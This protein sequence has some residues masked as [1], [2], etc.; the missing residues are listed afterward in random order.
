MEFAFKME[1]LILNNLTTTSL[2]LVTPNINKRTSKYKIQQTVG[3]FICAPVSV[4]PIFANPS[5]Y[6]KEVTYFKNVMFIYDV[7]MDYLC[8]VSVRC[9]TL[10]TAFDLTKTSPGIISPRA[11][12]T[13]PFA[14]SVYTLCAL[15]LPTAGTR[16]AVGPF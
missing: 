12:D 1:A 10:V 5:P 14:F 3:L 7:S 16:P 13:F 9:G 4:S 11:I 8:A 2:Q 15:F 6:S